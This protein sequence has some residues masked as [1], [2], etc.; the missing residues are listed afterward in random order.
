MVWALPLVLRWESPLALE[1][2]LV[3]A[4][5]WAIRF[6][7]LRRSRE[8]FPLSLHLFPRVPIQAAGLESLPAGAARCSLALRPRDLP[9]RGSK[10]CFAGL[11]N[12][13]LRPSS[14]LIP[15]EGERA[16]AQSG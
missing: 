14:E 11:R 10:R 13:W 3:L 16:R 9:P 1:W 5:E 4:S 7:S 12:S 6:R 8:V 15:G 2:M